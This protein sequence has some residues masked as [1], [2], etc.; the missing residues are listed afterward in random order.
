MKWMMRNAEIKMLYCMFIN[1][2][3]G[4]YREV[5][6]NLSYLDFLLNFLRE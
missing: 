1:V 5:T 6:F 3:L 4:C 2:S